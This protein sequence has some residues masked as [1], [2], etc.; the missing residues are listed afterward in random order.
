M[1]IA[2][3]SDIHYGT[4]SATSELTISGE[5]LQMGETSKASPLFHGLIES[6]KK[7]KPDFLFIAG[8]LT[9][10]GSPL[11]FRNCYQ[12]ISQLANEVKI[13]PNNIILCLGNH[14]IDWRITQL[15]DSYKANSNITY[16]SEEKD[17]L[18]NK[19]RRMACSWAVNEDIKLSGDTV[20]TVD[21]THPYTEAPLTGVVERNNCIIFVLNSA[22]LC[23]HD[24]SKK[25]GCLSKGQLQWFEDLV[26]RYSSSSSIKI[27][28]LH[29]HPFNYPFL[30]PERDISTLEEGSE[31]YQICGES[32]VDLVLH[33]HRHHPKAKTVSENGWNNP[34]TYICAGS[35]SV[36][37][38]HRFQGAIPNTFHIIEYHTREQIILKNYEYSLTDG[39]AMTKNYR[40]E[41]PLEGNMLL[42][43]PINV[44]DPAIMDLVKELPINEEI[45]FDSLNNDLSYLYRHKLIEL[46]EQTFSGCTVY[47]KPD[48]FI[49]FKPSGEG[50]Q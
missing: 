45:K 50:S 20:D 22:H 34:V 31:L 3:I 39:W 26:K 48:H 23:S 15:I 18:E 49:I 10:T 11:E 16:S 12:K 32:G 17:F 40:R 37:A 47:Q 25:H 24:E 43:K 38:T 30:F 44:H 21:L 33:G 9:S 13:D 1:R 28:L 29:H 19:Y 2:L 36:N 14:D 41:V 6:L 7:E 42:G 27:V 46:V 35:L 5:T 4:M 8:D